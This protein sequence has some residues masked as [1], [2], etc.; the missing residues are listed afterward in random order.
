MSFLR[1]MWKNSSKHKKLCEELA[2]ANSIRDFSENHEEIDESSNEAS[3]TYLVK[4]IG[5][6]PVTSSRS[7]ETTANAVKKIISKSNKKL[8]RVALAI[9][10]KGIEMSDHV[11]GEN[12][13]QVSIYRISY[14]SADASHSNVF[15]F[16]ESCPKEASQDAEKNAFTGTE[17]T[18]AEE[19]TLI[20]HA[21]LCQKR[22]MAQTVT[23]TVARSFERA[24][25]VW[26]NHQWQ[27]ERKNKMNEIK[28]SEEK[29]ASDIKEQAALIDLNTDLAEIC[30]K[31]DTRDYLQNT[32]IS[33]EDDTADEFHQIAAR[34]LSMRPG[35]DM[36]VLCS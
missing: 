15:A 12:L 32:W 2:L 28:S 30:A 13:L 23:L 26:Q 34:N 22:K 8:Q 35:W 9:S 27:M 25:Q 31:N 3:I 36:N 33:F 17:D 7:E 14:C 11:T 24:Y 20:C 21:F 16:I 5:Q 19:G 10:P 4:Y 18:E 1:S 29:K 6:I